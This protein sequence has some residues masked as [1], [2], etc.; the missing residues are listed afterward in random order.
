[1][2]TR[3]E[4]QGNIPWRHKEPRGRGRALRHTLLLSHKRVCRKRLPSRGLFVR[5]GLFLFN[6]AAGK[7]ALRQTQYVSVAVAVGLRFS[8]RAGGSD[9]KSNGGESKSSMVS[10]SESKRRRGHYPKYRELSPDLKTEDR[11]TARPRSCP[12]CPLNSRPSD[13]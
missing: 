3:P 6:F 10:Q 1:M 2:G 11:R 7:F 4:A 13:S 9:L 8:E 12:L 5:S